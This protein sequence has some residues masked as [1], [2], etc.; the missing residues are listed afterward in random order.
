MSVDSDRE[1]TGK[2]GDA[3]TRGQNGKGLG[4]GAPQRS[5][6]LRQRAQGQAMPWPAT[7]EASWGPTQSMFAIVGLASKVVVYVPV[8]SQSVH[9]SCHVV[10]KGE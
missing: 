7:I 2:D 4:P 8:L 5:L 3:G 10:Q 9:Q 1:H 6:P